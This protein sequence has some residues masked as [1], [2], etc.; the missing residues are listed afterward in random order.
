MSA[1]AFFFLPLAGRARSANL[2]NLFSYG[3]GRETANCSN[4]SKLRRLLYGWVYLNQNE[5]NKK[6]ISVRL[7]KIVKELSE[8]G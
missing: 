2:G 5:K 4:Y 8:I 6:K 3:G 1:G 7:E